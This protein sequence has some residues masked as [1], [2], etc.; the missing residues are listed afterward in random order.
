MFT[1]FKIG[2]VAALIAATVS[3]ILSEP[4]L[5][6]KA[7][8][9][10]KQPPIFFGSSSSDDVRCVL[11]SFSSALETPPTETAC[12]FGPRLAVGEVTAGR[13]LRPR[14]LFL[15]ASGGCATLASARLCY[16]NAA[17]SR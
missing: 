5:A 13:R 11:R 7:L 3:A 12:P 16:F 9:V 15:L 17:G 10:R 4:A 6:K 2:L 1:A 8:A 14:F